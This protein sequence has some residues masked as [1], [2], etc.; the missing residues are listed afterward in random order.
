MS[1]SSVC[2]KCDGEDSEPVYQG[3]SGENIFRINMKIFTGILEV[4]NKSG[5]T[6]GP[7]INN[8]KVSQ[9]VLRKT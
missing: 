1:V 9:I 7:E 4:T 5:I 3:Y 8:L 6:D 2:S